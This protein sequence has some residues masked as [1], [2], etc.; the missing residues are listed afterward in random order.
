MQFLAV[1]LHGAVLEA[2]F[3]QGLGHLVECHQFLGVV[4]LARLQ[5]LLHLFVGVAAVAF[6]DRMCDV[7]LLD[8]GIFV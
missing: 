5:Y 8:V 3:T 7:E 6:D 2:S 4:A 1:E